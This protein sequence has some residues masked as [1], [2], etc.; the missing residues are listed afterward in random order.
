MG[1]VFPMDL[2]NNVIDGPLEFLAGGA[3]V[4]AGMYFGWQLGGD[5][6]EYANYV[7]E[8]TDALDSLRYSPTLTK[9]VTSFAGGK[10]CGSIGRVA[11]KLVDKIAKRM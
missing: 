2:K 4:A 9:L 8:N 1:K 5:L 6:V 10:V 7:A 3:A 11:G